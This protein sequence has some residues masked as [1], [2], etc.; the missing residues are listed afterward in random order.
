MQYQY[1]QLLIYAFYVLLGIQVFLWLYSLYGKNIPVKEIL[2]F[3]M[4]ILLAVYTS[5][6]MTSVS[7]MVALGFIPLVLLLWR[8]AT[9]VL[10]RCEDCNAVVFNHKSVVNSELVASC[11]SCGYSI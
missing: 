3:G 8:G 5:F 10:K 11:S 4:K 6:A 2:N 1:Y 7:T 9:D